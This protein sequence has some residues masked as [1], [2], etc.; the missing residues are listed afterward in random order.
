M[1]GGPLFAAACLR[2]FG[3]LSLELQSSPPTRST[4]ALKG[5][6]LVP[7]M[8]NRSDPGGKPSKPQKTPQKPAKPA[9]V[10][11]KGKA[12]VKARAAN[13]ESATR[14]RAIALMSV[15]VVAVGFMAWYLIAA[16]A[17]QGAVDT[18]APLNAAGTSPAAAATTP[19][20]SR[21]TSGAGILPAGGSLPDN[22]GGRPN[23]FDDDERG[24]GTN[25]AAGGI[26]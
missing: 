23:K 10:A 3:I 8:L 11:V 5:V 9:P 22:G 15:I 12:A 19:Q 14:K 16:N 2:A 7:V 18:P 20:P 13:A 1:F 17:P 6:R 25:E 21:A 24:N 4:C 26:R